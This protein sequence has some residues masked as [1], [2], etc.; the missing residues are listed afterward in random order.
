MIA[1]LRPKILRLSNALPSI[2][3]NKP[4][5]S[6]FKDIFWRSNAIFEN[7]LAEI[8]AFARE[9][10]GER[11]DWLEEIS[12]GLFA[13]MHRHYQSL[14]LLQRASQ[15]TLTQ[16]FLC[17]QICETAIALVFFLEEADPFTLSQAVAQSIA[18][19]T[20]L[21]RQ[22]DDLRL[23]ETQSPALIQ[24]SDKLNHCLQTLKQRQASLGEAAEAPSSVPP[25]SD[26][27]RR[28][29]QLGLKSLISPRRQLL[30]AIPPA[31]FLDLHFNGFYR[32]CAPSDRFRSLRD[33]AHL[34]LHAT[35]AFIEVQIEPDYPQTAQSIEQDLTRLFEWFHQAYQAYTEAASGIKPTVV[36]LK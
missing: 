21:L 18:Q 29:A 33:V 6:A 19:A 27:A 35:R 15:D 31:S 2:S 1:N 17:E 23:R 30:L 9:I 28:G 25:E 36:E 10:E 14:T 11:Q 16:E 13:K 24:F 20:F 22:V 8:A 4:F 5:E 32:L 12:L 3:Q 7:Y 26:T 34:C